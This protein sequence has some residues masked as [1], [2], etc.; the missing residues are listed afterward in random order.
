M[1]DTDVDW[2]I[3]HLVPDEGSTIDIIS[4]KSGINRNE[5][6]SSISRLENTH[7]VHCDGE[8]VFPVSIHD[9]ILSGILTG[10]SSQGKGN[11]DDYGIYIENGVIKVRK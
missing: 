8:K 11:E 3:Y 7:L 5:V 4:E 10:K 2:M 9:F 6:L 1:N